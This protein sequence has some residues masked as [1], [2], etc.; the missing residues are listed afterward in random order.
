MLLPSW[1]EEKTIWRI[2]I[3][4]G[5]RHAVPLLIP[6][7][8]NLTYSPTRNERLTLSPRNLICIDWQTWHFPRKV[9]LLLL[10]W[11]ECLLVCNSLANSSRQGRMWVRKGWVPKKVENTAW[12]NP[13]NFPLLLSRTPTLIFFSFWTPKK[14]KWRKTKRINKFMQF[15]HASSSETLMVETQ[16]ARKREKSWASYLLDG[17]VEGSELADDAGVVHRHAETPWWLLVRCPNNWKGRGDDLSINTF[18][19]SI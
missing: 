3:S 15:M 19:Q 4:G 6:Y 16:K 17:W 10:Y 7:A 9:V 13:A 8:D 1:Q 18:W 12:R 2:W 11:V 14:R 5:Q